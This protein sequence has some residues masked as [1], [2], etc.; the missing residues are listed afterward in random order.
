VS[1]SYYDALPPIRELSDDHAAAVADV[2][3]P[4]RALA[5][6]SV[7][8]GRIVV[9]FISDSP[10]LSRM[11][12]DN[13]APAAA[14]QDPDATLYMLARPACGYGLDEALDGA[15]WWS[16]S[17]KTMV[18]FGGGSYRLAKVCIRGACSAVSG[19]DIVFM[20]GCALSIGAGNHRRGVVVAGGSGAGKTTLV[21][22]LL[23]CEEYSLAVLNDDWGA[24]SLSS[25]NS[26]ATG[27]RMLHMKSSSVRALRPGFF[28][29]APRDSYSPDPSEADPGVRLLVSPQTVYGPKWDNRSFVVDHVVVIVREGADWMPPHRKGDVI[30]ALKGVGRLGPRQHHEAFLNGSLIL[31]TASDEWREES[32]YQRLLDRVTVSWIN[33]CGSVEELVGKFLSAVMK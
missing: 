4:F 8:A 22:R 6:I 16:H 28:A 31:G 23:Q 12:A 19:D 18:V 9:A 33:N 15:R 26:V 32:R 14:G 27:E 7:P 29:R 21:A 3:F 11:F 30:R 1:A 20:H 5:S 2:R 17:G 10:E 25:G 13:W 24:V